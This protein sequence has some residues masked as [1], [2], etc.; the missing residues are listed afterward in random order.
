MF[1]TEYKINRIVVD[2]NIRLNDYSIWLNV[3]Y[4]SNITFDYYIILIYNQS[5]ISLS[6]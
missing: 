2:N 5:G 1:W 3:S 6:F 4:I